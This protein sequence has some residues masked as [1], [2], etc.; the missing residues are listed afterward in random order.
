MVGS[1]TFKGYATLDGRPQKNA[2]VQGKDWRLVASWCQSW[3]MVGLHPDQSWV[4]G[5]QVYWNVEGRGRMYV[6]NGQYA[7]F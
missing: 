3:A 6:F 7:S 4:G 1:E 2:K 5:S